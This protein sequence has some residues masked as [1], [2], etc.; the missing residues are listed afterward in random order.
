M[1]KR[2]V[3]STCLISCEIALSLFVMFGVWLPSAASYNRL[4]GSHVVMAYDQATF[5]GMQTQVLVVWGQMNKTFA[6][7]DFAT[8]YNSP[9]Y[10]EQNYENSL[11]ANQDYFR[12]FIERLDQTIEEKELIK[13]GNKTILVPYNSWYQQTLG[14]LRNESRRSG[15]LD[16]A[17]NGAWFLNFA[18]MAY[19][20]WWW[21]VPVAI[22]LGVMAFF[23][24]VSAWDTCTTLHKKWNRTVSIA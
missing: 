24:L 11:E 12:S 14:D 13:S 10:W 15:G 17:I 7:Y 3:V 21:Y 8:T 18:M 22:A 23:V 20:M 2:I 9:W 19:W 4:F 5:E 16:W 1:N 6:D